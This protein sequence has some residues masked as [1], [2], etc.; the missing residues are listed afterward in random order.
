MHPLMAH[1]RHNLLNKLSVGLLVQQA[2]VIK[3]IFCDSFG[4]FCEETYRTPQ[5]IV[6]ATD[7]ERKVSNNLIFT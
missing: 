1:L 7:A 6:A 4:Y 2:R 3:P 5:F